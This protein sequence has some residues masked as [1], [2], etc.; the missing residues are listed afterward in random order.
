MKKRVILFAVAICFCGILVFSAVAANQT[1]DLPVTESYV[2]KLFDS[3]SARI[4]ALSSGSGSGT[5]QASV[6]FTAIQLKKGQSITGCC[7]IILRSG[8]ATAV[9]PGINGLSDITEGKDVTNGVA[10]TAEHLLVIPR[11]DGR[12]VKVTTDDA[13]F[14]VRGDY[15]IEG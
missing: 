5:S 11:D 6:A 3:L 15:R 14:L 9:C 12:A 13:Y 10:L 8:K 1:D 2:T 4:D 7:E